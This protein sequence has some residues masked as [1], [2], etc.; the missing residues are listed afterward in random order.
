MSTTGPARAPQPSEQLIQLSTGFMVSSAL[1]TAATLKI[2]DLLK[3]GAK[4]VRYLAAAS[5]TNE[6]A[7]YRVLRALAS[8]GVFSETVPRTFVLTP[9]G[10]LLRSDR[11]D[12]V[13]FLDASLSR[14]EI[15][16]DPSHHNRI[17]REPPRRPHFRRGDRF[18]NNRLREHLIPPLDRNCQRLIRT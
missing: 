14:R 6:D 3:G 12:S 11:D 5:E 10:E 1:H 4:P 13:V 18:G 8:V 7:L 15:R 9:V 2:A 17:L 16:F